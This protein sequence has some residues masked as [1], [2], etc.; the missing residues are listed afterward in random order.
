MGPVEL[1]EVGVGECCERVHAELGGYENPGSVCACVRA[2]VRACIVD[3]ISKLWMNS[4][5]TCV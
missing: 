3:D 4:D 2:C 1:C 5:E